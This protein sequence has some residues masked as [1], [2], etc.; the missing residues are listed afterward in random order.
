MNIKIN[1]LS[2]LDSEINGSFG[3]LV[4]ELLG[5]INNKIDTIF[6]K[7]VKTEEL[8]IKDTCVTEDQLK[9]LLNNAQINQISE[10]EPEP[11]APDPVIP[12]AETPPDNTQNEIPVE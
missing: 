2:S 9:A 3:Y 10:Q 4:K 12:P 5:D 1:Q 8:C 11:Q 6:A 7:K